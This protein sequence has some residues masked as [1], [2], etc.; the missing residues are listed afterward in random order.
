M[1]VLLIIDMQKALFSN[2]ARYD[3][4]GVIERINR[5]SEKVRSQNGKVIFV[6]HDGT[7][8]DGLLP[9]TPGW[10]ILPS[11]KKR[12]SDIIIRKTICDSF[13]QTDLKTTLDKLDT[14]R[15]IITGCATDFC[16][17]TTVRAAVSH[18]YHV[19]IAS[20]CHTTADRPHLGAKQVIEHHNWVWGDLIVPEGSVEVVLSE[21]I[22]NS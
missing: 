6:Q 17:D 11:L 3:A 2:M 4:D 1:D 10:V 13:Y 20:D 14:S 7:E 16:V 5:L 12:D 18:E 15:L 21:N 19:V 22:W 8:E 9:S